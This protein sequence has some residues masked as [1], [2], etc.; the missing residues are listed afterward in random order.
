MTSLNPF[1]FRTVPDH[2]VLN[3]VQPVPQNSQTTSTNTFIVLVDRTVPFDW[4][5]A[6]WTFACVPVPPVANAGPNQGVALNS[7][8]TLD[9]SKS[10]N[11]SGLGTLT[12]NWA[13]A[14]RPAGTNAVLS[15]ATSVMPTFVA[16]VPNATWIINLTVSNGV[17]GVP[18]STASVSVT[19]AC[20]AP[21][22]NAGS[23]QAVPI[24]TTATLNGGGSTLGSC[25][26]SLT[27]SWKFI[28]KPAGS[29]ATLAG[30]DTVSPSFVPDKY[31]PCLASDNSDCY[32]VELTVNDGVLASGPSRVKV[33]TSCVAPVANAGP[34]QQLPLNS[35][36]QLNG[37][38]STDACGL[39]LTYQWT[40][41]TVPPGSHARLD[42]ASAVNPK[43]TPDMLG[44]Y[45]AQLIVTNT[46]GLKSSAST[47]TITPQPLPPSADAGPNQNVTS[48][49]TVQLNCVGNDPN[50]PQKLPLTYKWAFTTKPGGSNA[51]LS[52]TSIANPT[53]IADVTGDF[54]AE[55]VVTNSANLSS[56]NN[57]SSK[58]TVT[59]STKCGAAPTANPG[60]PQTVVVGDTVHLDGSKSGDACNGSSSGL[61]FKWSLLNQPPGSSA[62]LSGDTTATPSFVPDVAGQYV[63]QLIV[64]NG[65]PSQPVTVLIT[66]SSRG[67]INVPATTAL[68]VGQCV[69]FP[70]TLSATAP[71][72]GSTIALLS[73]DPSVTV[74]PATV[75]IVAGSNTPATQPQICGASF[76]SA[77]VSATNPF[78]TSGSGAVNVSAPT[79]AFGG[80]PLTIGGTATQNLTLTLSAALPTPLTVTLTSGNTAVATVPNTV[81]IPANTKTIPV[82]VTGV[83]PGQTTISASANGIASPAPATV[84]VK[85]DIILPTGLLIPPGGQL[86]FPVQLASPAGAGGVFITLTSS[87]TSKV[88]FNGGN[89]TFSVLIPAGQTKST[90]A[91]VNG[92]AEGDSVITAKAQGLA[93]ASVVVS[94][95]TQRVIVPDTTVTLG[96]QSSA[97][98]ITVSKAPA[99]N[100][101]VNLS[102]DSP[103]A[104]VSPASIVIPAGQTTS[105]AQV[106][107]YGAGIGT[108]NIIG[109]ATGYTSGSGKVTITAPTLAFTGSPLTVVTGLTDSQNLKLTLSNGQAP[110]PNGLTVNLSSSAPG[111]ATVPAT[112]KFAANATTVN[113]PVTGVAAGGPVTI[114]ATI[115]NTAVTATATANVITQSVLVANTSVQLGNTANLQVTAAPCA[116]VESDYHPHQR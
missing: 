116:H 33:S 24:N 5:N 98:A 106:Q 50:V 16:D 49:T 12:Y 19:T 65:Q 72:G 18:S 97:F 109:S 10:T 52:S 76:G 14:Q 45:V 30:A 53:F 51:T 73:S 115:P 99:A 108:A 17:P 55:C 83:A 103:N 95:G 79:I 21:T 111:T 77:T 84:I 11:P 41:I 6:Q 22:A 91:V 43:F 112:V 32:V 92:V 90:Q 105:A 80:S 26:K 100:L 69:A 101:T 74:S 107:V 29:V 4:K 37:S 28:S 104:T 59:I 7:T 39:P 64:N 38:G 44:D 57:P 27:Y 86:P 96:N 54:V 62:T 61:T 78:Y 1:S 68:Q 113:V 81:T 8:V 87:N 40:L 60:S 48:G 82:P 2:N 23:S 34:N 89:S 9:G 85:A 25:G 88:T 31:A 56:A 36:V 70:I 47:V 13:F 35:V 66:A 110:T 63:V 46:L 93:T 94:V 71:V 58:P 67:I 42:D 3:F 15:N 102:S 114:T 75:S 20:S